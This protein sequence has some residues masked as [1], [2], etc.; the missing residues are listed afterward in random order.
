MD[1]LLLGRVFRLEFRHLR[2]QIYNGAF[3]GGH[4]LLKG[5]RLRQRARD[6]GAKQEAD[7]AQERHHMFLLFL[8]HPVSA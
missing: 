1:L 6:S 8:T 4:P 7:V 3:E 2:L 5:G